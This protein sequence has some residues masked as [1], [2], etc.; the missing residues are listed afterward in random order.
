[1]RRESSYR[2][3]YAESGRVGKNECLFCKKKG[4]FQRDCTHYK[5]AQRLLLESKN[6][7]SNIAQHIEEN[8]DGSLY[9]ASATEHALLSST[10]TQWVIDSG[11][12]KHFTGTHSDFMQLKR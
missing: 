9:Y 7:S 5:R 1:M 8:E 2:G 6:E 12:S 11:A 3:S 4:H 10:T